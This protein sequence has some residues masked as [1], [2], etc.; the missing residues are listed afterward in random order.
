MTRLS[1]ALPAEWL[2]FSVIV[3][4]LVGFGIVI[5]ILPF[6]SPMLGGD[7]VDVALVIAIY[8]LGAGIV[9]PFWGG[10]SDRIGRKRVL[11][12]CLFG[13][14][15][16]YVLLGAA[17]QL[18]MLYA[19]RGFGGLMAGSLPVASALMADVS[20]PERRAKAMGLVGTAFGL[21]LILGPVIG[22]LLAGPGDSFLLPGLFAAAMSLLS[23]LLA[24]V[25]LPNDKP[26]NTSAPLFR[27]ES[28]KEGLLVFLHQRRAL[29]LVVQYA[30]HTCAV[31]SAIYLSPLWLAALQGWGPQE[32][33]VLFGLVGLAMILVQGASID[34]LT[35]R[36][37]LLN[38]LSA[39][40]CIF[41]VSLIAT[42]VVSGELSRAFVIFTAFTGATCCLPVLNTIASSIVVSAER[43]RMMGAT[44]LAASIGRVVG[45]LATGVV[46]MTLGYPA[47]WL[48]V[49]LPVIGLLL[50]S[51]RAAQRYSGPGGLEP[52]VVVSDGH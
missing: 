20:K 31:S 5:P 14:G 30:L 9:G 17:N 43:G 52:A 6:M 37:G 18:W 42:W 1:R 24:G 40:A 45:P 22:G 51:R 23:V 46:L 21:G 39:G 3:V 33:G 2:V 49:A 35:R 50:W 32:I 28:G 34:W 29:L 47:S 48:F 38:V 16:S 26:R 25:V 27:K 11:M 19:A 4:D 13:G 36:F 41:A 10:L 15:M 12:I 8:S 7:E 44:A